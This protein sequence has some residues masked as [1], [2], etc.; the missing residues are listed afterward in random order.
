M[1]HLIIL[2]VLFILSNGC[3][4]SGTPD[5]TVISTTIQ[6]K[7]NLS[8]KQK[9][10]LKQE[11][12]PQLLGDLIDYSGNIISITK[13]DGK[14]K[15]I[16]FWS[17]KCGDN[18]NFTGRLFNLPTGP[19]C[20]E[21]RTELISIAE[22]NPNLNVIIISLDKDI[23]DAKDFLEKTAI[24]P[25]SYDFW[26]GHDTENPLYWYSLSKVISPNNKNRTD[27]VSLI[28]YLIISEDGYITENNLPNPST[29]KNRFYQR[30]ARNHI[31]DPSEY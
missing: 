4:E 10:T 3:N 24:G 30:L 31:I 11:N 9:L 21:S 27:T 18:R 23:N 8:Y 13:F 15:L 6:S 26:I 7:T 22:S 17:S 16:G 20:I 14:P 25:T 29:N 19:N 12:K 5:N 1:K 28:K 2:I